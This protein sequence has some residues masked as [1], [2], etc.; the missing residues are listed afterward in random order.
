MANESFFKAYK[1]AAKELE[2]LVAEQEHIE[3]R[4]LSLRKTMN[5]LETVIS[6]LPEAGNIGDLARAAMILGETSLT[7][8]IAHIIATARVPLTASEIKT[9]LV[10]LGVNIAGH[11]NPLATIYSILGRLTESG[12]AHETVRNGKKAWE[13]M[14]RMAEAFRAGRLNKNRYEGRYTGK[15]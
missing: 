7:D 5:A 6:Q 12:R 4:I 13:R 9:E 3:K 8:E 2:S 11:S 1:D 15:K 14:T 10:E